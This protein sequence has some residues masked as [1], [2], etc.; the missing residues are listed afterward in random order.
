MATPQR[1]P[2]QKRIDLTMVGEAGAVVALIADGFTVPD[3]NAAAH[4]AER[5]GFKTLVVSPNRSLVS[6]RS[7]TNEEM[8][9][10]VDKNP[11]DIAVKD[12]HGLIL[13]GGANSIRR[14]TEDQNSR[15]LIIDFIKSGKPVFATGEALEVI[16]EATGKTG[17]TG[18][19]ALAINGE[20]FA[21]DS[22]TAV[23]D[24][25]NAFIDALS[26]MAD[27]A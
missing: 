5:G 9:F 27:A 22:E 18:T 15:L 26:V 24:A 11:G 16:A 17:V 13:P 1:T 3:L 2:R 19:A 10:V 8:N 6:G 4:A 20:V 12:Q 23:E 14:L 25:A 7:A 21:G